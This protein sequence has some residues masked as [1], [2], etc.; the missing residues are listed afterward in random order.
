MAGTKQAPLTASQ[1]VSTRLVQPGSWS[2]CT[3]CLAPIEYVPGG[4]RFLV[5]VASYDGDALTSVALLHTECY[6]EVS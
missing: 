1:R 4:R 5:A 3:H 2:P 6:V